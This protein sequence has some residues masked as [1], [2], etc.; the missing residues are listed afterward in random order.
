MSQP[1]QCGRRDPGQELVLIPVPAAGPLAERAGQ[2]PGGQRDAEE[3]RDR[4]DD[5]GDGHVQAGSREAEP[6]GQDLQVEEAEHGVEQDLE[7]RV[8]RDP[9]SMYPITCRSRAR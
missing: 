2:V 7:D 3:D 8:E 9:L 5:R 6:V 4:A 1:A